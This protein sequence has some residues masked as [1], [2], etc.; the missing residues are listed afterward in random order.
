MSN[1][2]NLAELYTALFDRAPDAD[3]L[4]YWNSE[5]ESGKSSLLDI[6][7][8]WVDS[9]PETAAKYSTTLSDNDF[10]D[11][12]YNN[13]LAR[14]AD[15]DGL[16]YWSAELKDGIITRDEFLV[17]I[18][19]GAKAN[20]SAQGLLDAAL[21]QNKAQVG[22]AFA[23]T[24]L[25]DTALAGKVLTPVT[26]DTSALNS[27]LSLLKLVPKTTAGQTPDLLS[28]F[29]STLDKVAQ[30]IKGATPDTALKLST[31]LST[32]ANTFG[33]T[34]N[35]SSLLNSISDTSTKALNDSTALNNPESLGGTAVVVA[36]PTGGGSTATF[37]VSRTLDGTLEFAGSATGNIKLSIDNFD[38]TAERGGVKATLQL[39][40]SVN[41]V[42]LPAGAGLE[43]GSGTNVTLTAA[44][45]SG[46]VITG[47]GFVN[48]TGSAGSQTLNVN[49]GDSLGLPFLFILP[50]GNKIDAGAGAD[51]I[52]L[53]TKP[54]V[55]DVI[56]IGLPNNSLY[57]D[58]ADAQYEADQA[59]ATLTDPSKSAFDQMA[60]IQ[61]SKVDLTALIDARGLL[62]TAF[63]DASLKAQ[64]VQ[65]AF[66]AFAT[67]NNAWNADR[68]DTA[69]AAAQFQA[70]SELAALSPS[71]KQITD[72]GYTTTLEISNHGAEIAGTVSIVQNGIVG[73]AAGALQNDITSHGNT[74]TLNSHLDQANALLSVANA[75]AGLVAGGTTD[76]T[77]GAQDVV[78]GFQLGTD[79][80]EF[81]SFAGIKYNGAFGDFTA[82]NGIAIANSGALSVDHI[83]ASLGTS[84]QVVAFIDGN[85]TVVVKGDGIAGVNDTDVVVRLAGVKATDIS[86]VMWDI[87]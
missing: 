51:V 71:F 9:Q 33:S 6:A 23:Q 11:A 56:K 67:A 24:G 46:H 84:Q 74:Q 42:K 65:T 40:G 8:N 32:I 59:G 85:D 87:A 43:V 76:S 70:Y 68:A 78:N 19:N 30:L 38:V 82:T 39:T 62:Q 53:G 73:P 37:T 72:A 28:Q 3:G 61:Q 77:A 29:S 79:R 14:S 60:L 64:V 50:T 86:Q 10:I 16:G 58:V 54:T 25:N 41:D 35:V 48:I 44:N 5:L 17:A 55:V 75:Q 34:A 66:E 15:S 4:A 18:L 21:I 69:L 49:S 81:S 80:I 12:I 7:R 36:T 22:L 13:V 63:D 45:A 1:Q 47:E 83:L 57:S 26:A 27:T 31:Y 52:N 20:T 2:S